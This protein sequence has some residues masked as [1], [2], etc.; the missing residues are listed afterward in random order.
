MNYQ[1]FE[2]V[3][4][5]KLFQGE[6]AE[7]KLL[8]T[9]VLIQLR[10][11][12][13]WKVQ[14]YKR[15]RYPIVEIEFDLP[16]NDET[17]EFAYQVLVE[18]EK[19]DESEWDILKRYSNHLIIVRKLNDRYTREDAQITSYLQFRKYDEELH[20]DDSIVRIIDGRRNYFEVIEALKEYGLEKGGR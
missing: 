12:R 15:E 20:Y 9:S 10:A 18:L 19:G 16:N 11:N 13:E 7:F 3:I 8:R 2:K 5:N 1:D 17:L 14:F 6:Y 4:L